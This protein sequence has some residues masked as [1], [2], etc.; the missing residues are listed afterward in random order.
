MKTF[1]LFIAAF[2]LLLVV[3]STTWQVTAQTITP[4]PAQWTPIIT[5]TDSVQNASLRHLLGKLYQ[6]TEYIR[7]NIEV[8]RL[9]LFS[10]TYGNSIC[11]QQGLAGRF[12]S[13][14]LPFQCSPESQT[15][16][17]AVSNIAY[18]WP[19]DMQLGT[20][21][22]NSNNRRKARKMMNEVYQTMLPIY[23][24][25][26][27]VNEGSKK[28]F[29]LPFYDIGPRLYSY[30]YCPIDTTIL[31]T[32]EE[33]AIFVN[34]QNLCAIQFT[35]LRQHHTLLTGEALVD[36]VTMAIITLKCKG[37][38]DMATFN[39][40]IYFSPDALFQSQHVPYF[41]DIDIHYRYLLTKSSNSYR[42]Y[43]KY[44]DYLPFDSIDV[45]SVPLDLTEY[46]EEEPELADGA[47]TLK[48]APLPA[49]IDSIINYQPPRSKSS[50]KAKNLRIKQ[51]ENI[52]ETLVDGTRLGSEENRLRIYG[53]LD[54]ATLGYDKF[55][56]FTIREQARYNGR[57]AQ[58]QTLYLRGELGY[59]FRLKEFRW[60][61][62]S[63]YTYLPQRRGRL[64]IEARR[65]TS[66][67]S[68]RFIN[69]INDALKADRSTVNF[70]SL[71]IEYYQRYDLDISHSIEL[72]NGLMLHFG[73]DY[74]YRRPVKRGAQKPDFIHRD[75]LIE[76]HYSD[77]APYILL[78]Y[79]PRQ[80]YWYDRGYK[81]YISSPAPT[82]SLELTRAIPGAFD[83]W[84]NYGR[85]EFDMQQLIRLSRTRNIA[86]HVGTGKF[87]NRKGEYFINYRYFARS[88]YPEKWEDDRIGG[89]FHLLDDYW[90]SSSPSYVQAHFMHETPFGL[91]NKVAP[92]SRFVIKERL[93][94]GSLW[95]EGKSLYTELGY[96]IDNNYFNVG[97]FVGFKDAAYYGCGIKFRIEIG[98]HL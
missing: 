90:Y 86:Y 10:Y 56:G 4:L 3:T 20:L 13:H 72:T 65:N 39:S 97:A 14:L 83:A 32:L 28:S 2:I 63:E 23:A 18:Q 45:E 87:F 67:F 1:S 33:H 89:T 58:G 98:S 77:F 12:F 48:N 25:S 66:T 88:Q 29:V 8:G 70:D 59:A 61:L 19:G 78:E 24:M 95:A 62:F 38:I 69:T 84:S 40:C 82:F 17:Q 50:K 64:T 21:L 53:P 51:L 26:R 85:A 44:I 68:S 41:S 36:S 5:E 79:T 37:R 74:T 91:I 6:H 35:P 71:G 57:F 60:R 94:L 43:Y 11:H 81:R 49:E 22:L 42:N 76:S 75:Y 93:Y 54:P 15:A 47:S 9:H 46:Y 92:I 73:I 31:Q 80:Y 30:Q 96:G 55:N 34:R 52:G 16:V 27:D 7:R